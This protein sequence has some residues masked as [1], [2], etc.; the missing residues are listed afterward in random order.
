MRRPRRPPGAKELCR[1]RS[2]LARPLAVPAG[3]PLVGGDRRVPDRGRSRRGTAAAARSGTTSSTPPGASATASTAEPGPDSYHRYREDVALLKRLGVDR[4]RFSISWVRVQ[5]R[6][7]AA[8]PAQAGIG[9]YDRVVDELLDAGVTP[10]P[11]LYHWDLPT[12]SRRRAAGSSARPRYRFADYAALVADALG[13]RVKSLVHDQRAG[14]DVAAGLRDRRARPGPAAA[15]RVAARPS[16]TSCSRTASP[17]ACLRRP[18]RRRVGIVNNHTDVRP[19][20]DSAEDASAP[21]TRLRRAAQPDLRRAGPARAL[22][23]P[24]GA[25]HPADADRARRSRDHLDADRRLRLQLLQ[26]DDDR[27]RALP[28]VPSPS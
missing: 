7:R 19:A 3:L 16:T 18:R 9:Y 22:S 21:R 25:R 24:R 12:P 13:D 11:T 2:S 4:Y 6:A 10:F 28:A 14:L 1:A 8:A 27:R 20:S 26:P 15:V 5:P 23:R 17:P